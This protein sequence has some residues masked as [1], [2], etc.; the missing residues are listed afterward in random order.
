MVVVG[1]GDDHEKAGVEGDFTLGFIPG[2]VTVLVEADGARVSHPPVSII[3]PDVE[4]LGFPLTNAAKSASVAPL[5]SSVVP[6]RLPKD[7][8]SS[9]AAAFPLV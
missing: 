5:V 6:A 1:A 7:M 9:L 8:K 3:L 2:E 4:E